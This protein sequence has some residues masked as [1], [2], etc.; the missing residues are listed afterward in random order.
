MMEE[1]YLRTKSIHPF[2][3]RMAP[4]IALRALEDL[5]QQVNNGMAPRVLDPMCGS[6]TVLTTAKSY[7]C[8]AV[9]RDVDP[10]AV[11]IT[12]VAVMGDDSFDSSAV[13]QEAC[14]IIAQAKATD[15]DD[16]PWTDSETIEFAKYW[17]GEDQRIQLCRLTQKIACLNNGPIKDIL[18]LSLSRLIDTKCPRA[19][20]ASDTSHSRPHKTIEESEYDVYK[21][22]ANAV[23]LVLKH[24]AK[25]SWK[26]D[27][28][29][30][31][32]DAR[33]LDISDSSIDVVI[34]SPP[35]LNAIDYMRGHKLSLIW[36]G[37]T[38]PQLR[39]IRSESV[40]SN[41][42]P[43][44]ETKQSVKEMVQC[45]REAAKNADTLPIGVIE[46]YADDMCA[47][48]E[49]IHRVMKKEATAVLVVGNSTIR[50]NYIE[51]D[52]LTKLACEQAGLSLTDRVEREI[53]ESSRYLPLHGEALGK[54]M[55]AEVVLTFEKR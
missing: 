44:G 21:G 7:G 28:D 15:S 11:L 13:N 22:F 33:S 49:E 25:N 29:V 18:N 35:Y 6:G 14:N 24:L 32:G 9:G 2:P 1:G 12:K 55:R 45:V 47:I 46:R 34:T 50:G 51:N 40:G 41:R 39:T 42:R 4:E 43:S 5:R 27:A 8:Q 48:A 23:N 10:L 3:A 54:R 16:Y 17:F 36:M 20:L 53:P 52:K 19:S 26:S 30:K 31:E 38:I 37:Y